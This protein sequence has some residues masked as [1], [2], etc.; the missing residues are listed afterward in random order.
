ML[1]VH[2]QTIS[3]WERGERQIKARDMDRAVALF[4]GLP[5]SGL[6]RSVPRGTL[7]HDTPT[8]QV[9]GQIERDVIRRGATD[10]EADFLLAAISSPQAFQL[11]TPEGGE[12]STDAYAALVRSLMRWLDGWIADRNRTD[13]TVDG[14]PVAGA[15]PPRSAAAPAKGQRKAAR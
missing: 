14:V 8:G 10:L 1:H 15:A 9:M 4:G 11:C 6:G 2:A 5:K 13:P 3:R 12:L 7:Y